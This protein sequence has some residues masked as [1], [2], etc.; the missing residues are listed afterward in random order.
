MSKTFRE[1]CLA[2][3]PDVVALIAENQIKRDV[4][5]KL[6]VLRDAKGLTQ[7]DVAK[8]AGMTQSMIARLEAPTGPEPSLKSINRYVKAC[9]GEL[10][11]EIN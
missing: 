4:A 9:G 8:A 3:R 10:R 11:I 1:K 2:A 7:A 6:R 5:L